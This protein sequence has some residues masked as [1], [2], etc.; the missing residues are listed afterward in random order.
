M[1]FVFAET[2]LQLMRVEVFWLSL[3]GV[4]LIYSLLAFW[5]SR[6]S[7]H[8][9]ISFALI[10]VAVLPLRI[11]GAGDLMLMQ[12]ANSLTI[13][14]AFKGLKRTIQLKEDRQNRVVVDDK[15]DFLFGLKIHAK[16]LQSPAV[17]GRDGN[18]FFV[19][20]R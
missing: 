17:G 4:W 19:V 18:H 16:P 12:L 13:F 11:I 15:H 9:F 2:E 8:W 14:F 6:R 10:A 20:D 5:L 1:M 3:V 7:W